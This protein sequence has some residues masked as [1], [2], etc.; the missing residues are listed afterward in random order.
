MDPMQ[1][2]RRQQNRPRSLVRLAVVVGPVLLVMLAGCGAEA[3]RAAR[4]AAVDAFLADGRGAVPVGLRDAARLAGRF[5]RVY[6]RHAYGRRVPRIRG[7]GRPVRRALAA[8][9]ARVPAGR[10]RLR[11]RL[12]GLRLAL[13]PGGGALVAT[14]RIGDGR[15]PPFTIGFTVAPTDGRWTVTSISLP[16]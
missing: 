1:R 7:E 16:N 14:A 2:L 13:S 10:W 8:S 5:A 11:P 9:A 6:A 12:L 15:F 3:P 4:P